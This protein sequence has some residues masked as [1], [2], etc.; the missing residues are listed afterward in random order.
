MV[1][2]EQ[3]RKERKKISDAKSYQKNKEKRKEYREKHYQENKESIREAN[4]KWK[5]ENKDKFKVYQKNYTKTPKGQ[6]T[7]FK[8]KWKHRGLD[9]DTFE[10][11][12]QRYMDSSQCDKCGVVFDTENQKN[13]KCMDHNHTTG[14][15]RGIL[16]SPCNVITHD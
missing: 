12:Y 15:F 10:E 7:L 9:M 6:K 11:A 2:T 1:F 5:A 8:G 16:C 3:E 14:L 13:R 4:D